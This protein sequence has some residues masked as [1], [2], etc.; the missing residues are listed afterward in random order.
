[1]ANKNTHVVIGYF[2]NADVAD[3]A[4]SQLKR[5]DNAHEAI[6]LGGIGIL[7]WEGDK[8]KT[9]KVGRRAAGTGAKW[10]L[11]LGAVTGIL[12][13]GVTIIGA[14]I[15]GAA[16]GAVLGSLFHQGLGLT[17]EDYARLKQQLVDGW[18]AVVV[19]A[20]EDEVSTTKDELTGMGGY[21]EAYCVPDDTTDL[22]ESAAQIE[23]VESDA[24][25]HVDEREAV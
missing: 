20:D 9:R 13:G 16:S 4:A 11:A 25:D 22:I 17:D 1:M 6:K 24:A 3:L 7:V 19:M 23:H 18:A 21:V 10:G 12:S 2:R 14:S 5:W 15:A 8:I